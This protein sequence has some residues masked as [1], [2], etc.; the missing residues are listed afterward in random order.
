MEETEGS[1][2]D[3]LLVSDTL[4]HRHSHGMLESYRGSEPRWTDWDVGDRR[5]TNGGSVGLILSLIG[6]NVKVVFVF[7]NAVA[8]RS[9]SFMGAW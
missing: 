7:S 1:G 8:E 5:G 6:V 4:R 9:F 2:Q 3:I